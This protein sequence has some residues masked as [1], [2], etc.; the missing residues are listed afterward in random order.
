MSDSPGAIADLIWRESLRTGDVVP[1]ALDLLDWAPR[2][3]EHGAILRDCASLVAGF[4]QAA[5]LR[6][7]GA[8]TIDIACAEFADLARGQR[9]SIRQRAE[10]RPSG[11]PDNPVGIGPGIPAREP[12]ADPAELAS[13]LVRLLA[14]DALDAPGLV[15]AIDDALELA[16]RLPGFDYRLF[17]EASPDRLAA[18]IGTAALADFAME[19]RDLAAAPFGSPEL[20]WRSARLDHRGL[21]PWFR[22]VA[23]L[24]RGSDDL[25]DLAR[26]AAGR[27]DEDEWGAWV[28]LLSRRL[29]N[30]MFRHVADDIADHGRTAALDA[31]L[32][33]VLARRP[34]TLDLS[35]V[36]YLRDA[37]LDLRAQGIAARAQAAICEVRSKDVLE[38]EILATIHADGG[39]F[40]QA[41]GLLLQALRLAPAHAGLRARL[42][43]LGTEAFASFSIPQGFASPPDRFETRLAL[44]GAL[45]DYPRQSGHRIAAVQV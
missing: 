12:P 41:Q 15:D 18:A 13:R 1:S 22:N 26:R 19:V 37:A 20:L 2:L 35:T 39:E 25:F 5:P 8:W 43:T 4:P 16:R 33:R 29:P 44:R 36:M 42:E 17:V 34:A 14:A 28:A 31:M 11:R 45:P 27:G 38:L 30:L 3:D 9:L 6:S 10:P 24:I 23:N 40:A 32:S 21:G 7:Q